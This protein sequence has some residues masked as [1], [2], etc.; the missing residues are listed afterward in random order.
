MGDCQTINGSFEAA[1][2]H[3]IGLSK[4]VNFYG[5]IWILEQ[6]TVVVRILSWQVR[7]IRK[8]YETPNKLQR[9]VIAYSTRF[10]TPLDYPCLSAEPDISSETLPEDLP[11][12]PLDYVASQ[13]LQTL[14]RISHIVSLPNMIPYQKHAVVSTVT[15]TEYL[16]LS[17]TIPLAT[18]TSAD[19]IVS[20]AF[21]LASL[22]YLHLT[23]RLLPSFPHPSKLHLRLVS[24]IFSLISSI[25][26]P[27]DASQELLDLLLWIVFICSA[28]SGSGYLQRQQGKTGIELEDE[29]RVPVQDLVLL[30]GKVDPKV[31][32]QSKW[33]VT[34]RL[35]RVVW[36]HGICDVLHD[37]IFSI[38][39]KMRR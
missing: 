31:V 22:L 7:S 21:M 27:E 9:S 33:E 8:K 23:F 15:N 19:S 6:N 10:G 25:S 34:Q 37:G 35:K 38:V 18:Q 39:E 5:G 14:R 4:M 12:L 30:M 28:A 32:R 11:L 29:I 3:K 16:I 24:I 1:T 26:Q 2:A 17:T 20:Q 36:R 13:L